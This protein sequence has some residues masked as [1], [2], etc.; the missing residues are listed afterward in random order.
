M[1]TEAV[2]TGFYQSPWGGK[3]YP[4]VQILT[5]EELLGGKEIH[6][7]PPSQ[8]SVTFKQA[9]RIRRKHADA[10]IPFEQPAEEE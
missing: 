10:E 8:T 3:R 4:K 7:P 9:K 5:I 1:T 6:M 2:G